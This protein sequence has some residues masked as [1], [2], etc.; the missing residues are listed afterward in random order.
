MN[1]SLRLVAACCRWPDDDA[2]RG[3][4]AEAARGRPDW[5][6]MIALT[7]A[8]RVEGL[9]AHGLRSAEIPIPDAA[10][11]RIDAAADRVRGEALVH[12]GETLRLSEALTASGI[13]HRVLKGVPLG[14]VAYG[15]PTLKRSWDIDLLVWPEQAVAAAGILGDLGYRP[16][17]PGGRFGD[18]EFRRW[19]VVSKEI[20]L[21]S[22]GGL[23]VE[24]HWRL[25]EHP[26][27]LRGIGMASEPQSIPLIGDRT[28]LTLPDAAN[29]AYLAVH[30]AFHGW[31]RL[32]WLAD[33][34][35]LLGSFADEK[36]EWMIEHARALGPGR[37]LDQAMALANR[38]FGT[39]FPSP[40]PL[41]LPT[42]RLVQLGNCVIETREP[43]VDIEAD[44]TAARAVRR[45]QW[46]LAPGLLYRASVL[47]QRLR[48]SEDRKL[49]PLPRWLWWAYWPIRPFTAA[50]RAAA[51]KLRGV[52]P[53]S[54]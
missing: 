17:A 2:R 52:H 31:S 15:T 32:K 26:I 6:E 50:A 48:G 42:E 49:I 27:L 19:Q 20:E 3:L 34:A 33:F 51:R 39:A 25:S 5:D 10:R 22:T 13:D 9:V 12:L 53:R 38:L 14:M 30:G 1:P 8:H 23:T 7:E 18:R 45:A 29:L 37:A 28:V 21:R 4:I 35:A 24:L 16:L 54:A 43:G 47:L 41:D 36:R 40:D 11:Q 46:L 44:R